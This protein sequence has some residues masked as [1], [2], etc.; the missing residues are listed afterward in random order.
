MFHF[1]KETT[2]V[3]LSV[4]RTWISLLQH[5]LQSTLHQYCASRHKLNDVTWERETDQQLNNSSL[6]TRNVCWVLC[7]VTVKSA[8][9][10]AG[11][12][13]SWDQFRG[14]WPLS[15]EKSHWPPTRGALELEAGRGWVC[16]EGTSAETLPSSCPSRGALQFL[17][18]TLWTTVLAKLADRSAKQELLIRGQ[19]KMNQILHLAAGPVEVRCYW[20]PSDPTPLIAWPS[21]CLQGWLG[22]LPWQSQRIAM[23]SLDPPSESSRQHAQIPSSWQAT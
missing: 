22:R 10:T 4:W 18:G 16:W 7:L 21:W 8:S 13:T 23:V 5:P 20:H 11:R 17:Q 9:F 3:H 15:I 12:I 19:L 14:R 6:A 2:E 1:N